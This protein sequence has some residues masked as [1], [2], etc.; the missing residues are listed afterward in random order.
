MGIRVSGHA[1][2]N[3]SL[4]IV[5]M[6]RNVCFQ[7]K[8]QKLPLKR[9]R[10]GVPLVSLGVRMALTAY[11]PVMCVMESRTVKMAL[12][13]RTVPLNAAQVGDWTCAGVICLLYFTL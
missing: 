9:R 3:W 6:L 4:Y 13:K 11:P 1:C 2:V 7:L 10:S 12:M 8:V 5:S